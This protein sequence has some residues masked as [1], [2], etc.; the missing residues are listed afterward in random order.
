MCWPPPVGGR[1]YGTSLPP[2]SFPNELSI[3][4]KKGGGVIQWFSM[5]A[6]KNCFAPRVL[7]SAYIRVVALKRER[8][9]Q[10]RP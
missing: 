1:E 3:K 7:F 5:S 9:R 6:A 10:N 2:A 4:E 8:E